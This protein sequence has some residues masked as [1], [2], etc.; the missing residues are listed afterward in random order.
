AGNV[1][2]Y[3]STNVFTAQASGT[4]VKF[5]NAGVITGY[6]SRVDNGD[7]TY[8]MLYR[9]SGTFS[10]KLVNGP[11]LFAGGG[12]SI[13][14]DVYDSATNQYITTTFVWAPP[15]Q[16]PTVGNPCDVIVPALT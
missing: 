3:E 4:S 16:R 11:I 9:S 6:T 15:T 2:T 5:H 12:T 7:G 13:Q 14:A 10:V 1:L 8:S